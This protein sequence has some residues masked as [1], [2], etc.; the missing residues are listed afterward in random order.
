MALGEWAFRA[1]HIPGSIFIS[2][3]EDAA[4]ALQKDEEIVVYCTGG[5]CPASRFAGIWLENHGYL[6]VYHYPGGLPD[7]EA[8]G[9]P[10]E[11]EMV[12]K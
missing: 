2:R 9:Y 5:E 7:W 4:S 10:L 11:G 8:A 6:H 1:K 3:M 12:A